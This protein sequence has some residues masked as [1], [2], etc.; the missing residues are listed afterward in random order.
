MRHADYLHVGVYNIQFGYVGNLRYEVSKVKRV[1]CSLRRRY[2]CTFL[3]IN[4][5]FGQC[6]NLN[7]HFAEWAIRF[8]HFLKIN[9]H[10]MVPAVAKHIYSVMKQI[11]K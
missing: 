7:T 10:S 2:S 4:F 5:H 1:K 9:A 8:A 11:N 6:P 3:E